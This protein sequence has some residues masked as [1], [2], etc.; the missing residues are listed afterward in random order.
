MSSFSR[1]RLFIFTRTFT[2]RLVQVTWW[3][4]AS[5]GSEIQARVEDFRPNLK[6]HLKYT[7]PTFSHF[8]QKVLCNRGMWVV[9]F[10]YTIKKY[11]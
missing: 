1:F 8:H 5:D 11:L 4:L 6:L 7:L 9:Y 3:F 2:H 10:Q